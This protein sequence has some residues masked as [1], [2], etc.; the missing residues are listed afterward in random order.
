M[1][2]HDKAARCFIS[3]CMPEHFPNYL[4]RQVGELLVHGVALRPASP[5]GFGFLPG[6]PPRPV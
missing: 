6:T 4:K 1:V 2:R 5:A 3:C